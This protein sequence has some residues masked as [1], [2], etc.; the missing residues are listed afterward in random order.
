[1]LSAN[2]GAA[3]PVQASERAAEQVMLP[4]D[5]YGAQAVLSLPTM[6]VRTMPPCWLRQQRPLQP[7]PVS[8][9]LTGTFQ[10]KASRRDEIASIRLSICKDASPVEND[11]YSSHY[12]GPKGVVPKTGVDVQEG[13]AQNALPSCSRRCRRI[14]S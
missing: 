5:D 9:P 3:H 11:H 1:M 10:R 12:L 2:C 7:R 8:A 6:I 4:D 13:V 14:K